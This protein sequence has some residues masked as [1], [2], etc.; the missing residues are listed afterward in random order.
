MCDATSAS[1]VR[2]SWSDAV[3]A[4]HTEGDFVHDLP[5]GGEISPASRPRNSVDA[6]L[7]EP[8]D[9]A[10]QAINSKSLGSQTRVAE[11]DVAQKPPS[12]GPVLQL[13]PVPPLTCHELASLDA[14]VPPS[15][16]MDTLD[17]ADADNLLS[18]DFFD[19]FLGST[20]DYIAFSALQ[21]GN[22]GPV[23]HS[24][25]A[26]SSRSGANNGLPLSLN[27]GEAAGDTGVLAGDT[28]KQVQAQDHA[29]SW[30]ESSPSQS[31]SSPSST[32]RP[33][34]CDQNRPLEGVPVPLMKTTVTSSAERE[35]LTLTDSQRASLL[36]DLKSGIGLEGLSNFH[37]PST[38]ALQKCLRTYYD[39]FHVH[40][41]FVHLHSL[42]VQKPPT[43]LILAM[44][45]I[46][47]LYRLE[48]K[49]AAAL[50]AKTHQLLSCGEK[51]IAHLAQSTPNFMET[52]VRPSDSPTM[53]LGPSLATS[54]ARLILTF[55]AAFNGDPMLVRK[56]IEDCGR[57]SAVPFDLSLCWHSSLIARCR[58]F[59]RAY[60]PSEPRR[61][62]KTSVPGRH[63]CRE[64]R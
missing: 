31:I 19:P 15:D 51:P 29:Q 2:G 49:S 9:F 24:P 45:A 39:A 5:G 43:P 22:T 46:G 56:A 6:F 35:A 18:L 12:L 10:T 42:C 17:E 23:Q 36:A 28:L 53:S 32:T 40:F 16:S 1:T 44:C 13:Q 54:Q 41:P 27:A 21:S 60:P 50:F 59:I 62:A 25:L 26:E 55:F 8:T 30:L 37:L 11:N 20:F 52:W 47:A 61:P 38:A 14:D 63:G 7:Q 33:R 3:T 57:I 34:D 4:P 48:R 58:I 64:S